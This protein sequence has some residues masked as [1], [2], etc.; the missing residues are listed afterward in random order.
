LGR[1]YKIS[2]LLTLLLKDALFY[3]ASFGGVT[4]S[5]GEPT[6]FPLYVGAL[7]RKLKERRIHTAIQT[8]GL[9]VRKDFSKYILPF[10]DLVFFDIKVMD[11]NLHKKYTG[12]ENN[13]ILENLCWLHEEGANILPTI[14]LIPSFTDS[15]ENLESVASFLKDLKIKECLLLPYNPLGL[16]KYERIGKEAPSLPDSFMEDLKIYKEIFLAEGVSVRE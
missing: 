15:R 5:G 9:F 14:P 13:L 10:V 3:K 12:V 2:E 7:L 4:L 1:R 8:C 16:Q 11:P 6:M